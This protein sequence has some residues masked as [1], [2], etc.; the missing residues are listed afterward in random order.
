MI[1]QRNL[2]IDYHFIQ[3]DTI[4]WGA[5]NTLNRGDHCY[6]YTYFTKLM[7]KLEK[8][9]TKREGFW[10][11]RVAILRL[12]SHLTIVVEVATKEIVAFYTLRPC[13]KV[14][15]FDFMQVFCPG[16]GLGAALV[17]HESYRGGLTM[18]D[19]LPTSVGFWQKMGIPL[20]KPN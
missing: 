8:I 1:S 17:M 12:V 3:F 7:D 20:F 16:K 4:R 2:Q 19:P 11:N 6:E 10:H 18:L 14:F 9:S 5:S 15:V 13:E